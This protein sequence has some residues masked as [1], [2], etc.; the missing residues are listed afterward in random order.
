MIVPPYAAPI[1]ATSWPGSSYEAV[2]A[3]S[4]VVE[5]AT[6]AFH[7]CGVVSCGCMNAIHSRPAL[8]RAIET[9]P[10]PLTGPD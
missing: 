4:L 10:D 2:Q 6:A 3:A 8:S 1:P 5:W 9:E 7:V